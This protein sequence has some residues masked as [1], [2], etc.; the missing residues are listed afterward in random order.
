MQ[1]IKDDIGH[2]YLLDRLRISPQEA[3]QKNGPNRPTLLHHCLQNCLTAFEDQSLENSFVK[4]HTYFC[5]AFYALQ[6]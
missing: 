2:K 5:V 3:K 1:P 6:Q 4:S